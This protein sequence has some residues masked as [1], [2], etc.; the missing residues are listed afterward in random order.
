MRLM[1]A[2]AAVCLTWAVSSH[3]ASYAD[4]C[5]AFVPKDLPNGATVTKNEMRAAKGVFPE[6]CIVRGTIVSGPTSTITWAVELPARGVWNGKTLT[7][8]GGGFDGFTPTDAEY[9]HIMATPAS[10]PY[11]RMG[12]DSG[13][14]VLTFY[15]WAQDDVALKNHAFEANHLTLEVG[16]EVVAQ[17][18]G[19][20]PTRRYMLGQ[21]NGG[22]SGLVAAQRYPNDYDGIVAIEPAINQQAHQV[23][24]GAT[25]MKHIF[26]DPDNWLSDAKVALFA[27]AEIAACDELD[28]LKD[29]V[30]ANIAA[31]T[32]IPTD[33]QC[34][35]VDNDACLTAGQIETIRMVYS[36]QNVP[37][38]LADG[39]SGYARFGRGG[40]ATTD[41]HEYLFGSKFETREAFNYMAPAQ[42]AKVVEHNEQAAAFPHDAA[43]FK[44]G[45][46]RV[47]RLMDPTNPDLSAFASH[48]K[49]LI[50]YGTADTCVSIYQTARYFDRVKAA[51][52]DQKVAGFAR[53]LVTPHVG[54]E[55]NGPGPAEIDVVG[56]IDAWVERGTAPDYLVVTK[57]DP[58]VVVKR[59]GASHAITFERPACEFPKFARYNGSGDP[60][61]AAS[62]HCSDK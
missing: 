43:A 58:L 14:Q 39:T 16:T 53:F 17:F 42:I 6:A 52:G 34:K 40:A 35:G 45:Y 37:V 7:F 32:Y 21:S 3:A 19:K 24:L 48:G 49:L 56:A 50:W 18:Y 2:L 22:R 12:S 25:T 11:A 44:D 60:M 15:P 47:S 62:F 36:D 8:G 38:T 31:C 61:K 59:D 28:G 29:G 33:L 4:E 20:K 13:H 9:Y 23:N 30:I 26:S 41:W 54:H 55:M 51:M 46:L 5:A 57:L 1:N 27:K 10:A